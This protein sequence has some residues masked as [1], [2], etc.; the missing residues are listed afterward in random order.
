VPRTVIHADQTQQSEFMEPNEFLENPPY[1]WEFADAAQREAATGFD[2]IMRGWLARQ[3]DDDSLWMLTGISPTVWKPMGG[4]SSHE[5]GHSLHSPSD[6]IDV[7]GTPTEGQ[8]LVWNASQAKWLPG[9]VSGAFN[10]V[11]TTEGGI[12]YDN[13]EEPVLKG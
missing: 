11:M 12:V 6:H 10:F 1:A 8:A 9:S 5:R 3:L 7:Q 4:T 2:P 13:S